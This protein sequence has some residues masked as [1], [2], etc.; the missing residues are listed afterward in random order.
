MIDIRST[1]LRLANDKNPHLWRELTFDNVLM[2]EPRPVDDVEDRNTGI[3]LTGILNRGYR[4]KTEVYYKRHDLNALFVGEDKPHFRDRDMSVEHILERVNTRYGLYLQVDDFDNLDF[5][6]FTDDDLETSRDIELRVKD[7]S[8]GWVGTVTIE[9]RYGNPLIESVVIVQLLPI[10]EHPDD[11][12]EL[13]SRR[14]GIV[15]TW[16]FDFTAWKDE[17][18]INLANG[19]WA[20]FARVQEIGQMAGIPYWYN[21]RVVD[22]PTS[23]VPGSNPMFERVMVQQ[24]ATGGVM[25]PLYFHYDLNW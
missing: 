2:S 19:Q 10:L 23:S 18:T 4:N 9:L 1:L 15:S 11:L 8:Y 6:E 7:V 21:G 24:L 14:S 16:A 13:D 25:G 22:L 5:G 12:V 20:N 17:L 3:M